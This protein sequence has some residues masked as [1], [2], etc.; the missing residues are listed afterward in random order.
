LP[1]VFTHLM[2]G[3]SVAILVR[4]N[5]NRAEQMLIVLGSV[6][7]DIERPITWLLVGTELEWIELGYAF[8]SLLSAAVLSFFAASCFTLDDTDFRG[9]VV[10]IFIG[11]ISHLALDLTMYP[12]IEVGLYLL[13]PLTIPFSLN[14]LWPDFWFFPVL[15]LVALITAILSRF[16]LKFIVNEKPSG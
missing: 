2:V 3:F 15:G 9:R 14:L 11:C 1:D 16:G 10:L 4:R 7:I 5:D 8:H 12:W 13:Y 6:L